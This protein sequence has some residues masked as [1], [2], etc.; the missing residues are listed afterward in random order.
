MFTS[1][2]WF[3]TFVITIRPISVFLKIILY[4]FFV[5]HSSSNYHISRIF[6]YFFLWKYL[7][8]V[9]SICSFD[10]KSVFLKNL[11]ITTLSRLMSHDITTLQHW[12]KSIMIKNIDTKVSLLYSGELLMVLC[13]FV[14]YNSFLLFGKFSC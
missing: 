8:D 14:N 7:R 6:C 10:V 3:F 2:F 4:V 13:R 5:Y 1:W 11:M 12:I 9:N